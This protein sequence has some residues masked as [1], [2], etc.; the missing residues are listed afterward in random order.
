MATH[1][2]YAI[3]SSAPT[4]NSGPGTKR[5]PPV[6]TRPPYSHTLAVL[7]EIQAA[8][9]GYLAVGRFGWR[10]LQ[11]LWNITP[12]HFDEVALTYLHAQTP[13][14]QQHT[15]LTV[16]TANLHD[17]KNLSAFLSSL[18]QEAE[19]ASPVCLGF[20][21]GCSHASEGCPFGHP[22]ATAGWKLLQKRWHVGMLDFDYLVLNRLLLK[23][24]RMQDEVLR[25]L[26]CMKLREVRNVSALLASTLRQCEGRSGGAP[27]KPLPVGKAVVVRCG[28]AVLDDTAS[29]SSTV[30]SPSGKDPETSS[31]E[32]GAFLDDS[33][34]STPGLSDEPPTP[35]PRSPLLPPAGTPLPPPRG[36]QPEAGPPA[37]V[38]QPVP[39]TAAVLRLL[40]LGQAAPSPA[41]GWDAL[42]RLWGLSPAH[43]APAA[44]SALGSRSALDQEHILLSMA[45]MDLRRAPDHSRLLT[46]AMNN[47]TPRPVC[48]RHLAGLCQN[49]TACCFQHP[50][51]VPAWDQLC[52]HGVTY[53]HIEYAV[54]NFLLLQAPA[55][56]QRVLTELLAHPALDPDLVSQMLLH[57]IERVLSLQ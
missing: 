46:A 44:L 5:T 41:I 52:Q 49:L 23:P 48:W 12:A 53:A 22:K 47:T 57:L 36:A 21:A 45:A 7:Q 11:R 30:G 38:A 29:D 19:E 9:E 20:L 32:C 8:G 2:P 28:P 15:L 37:A 17:V 31:D 55:V 33:G 56:Q 24:R 50:M 39:G 1:T 34:R 54:L 43:F 51:F 3:E 16:A 42:H 18:L 40:R 14:L 10:V 4:S 26:A 13:A 25:C 35:T 6:I 27:A